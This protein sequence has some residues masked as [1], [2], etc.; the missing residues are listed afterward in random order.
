MA[1]SIYLTFSHPGIIESGSGYSG[2]TFY[3]LGGS[4]QEGT[5][6][7]GD[8][9]WS[10]AI[11]K[12]IIS[13]KIPV[14][15]YEGGGVGID[16]GMSEDT[17]ELKYIT[18]SYEDFRYLGALCKTNNDL[19]CGDLHIV[20][21]NHHD[22]FSVALKNVQFNMPKAKGFVSEIKLSLLVVDPDLSASNSLTVTR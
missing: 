20:V 16:I 14:S 17:F 6:A 9:E 22:T 13:E 2:N 1:D 18:Y 10:R 5:Y 15:T 11:N 12:N 21:Q 19:K 4:N 8:F 3:F 7:S